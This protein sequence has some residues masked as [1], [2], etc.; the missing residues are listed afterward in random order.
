M[1]DQFPVASWKEHSKEVYAVNWNLATKDTFVS[2]SWDGTIKM[3]NFP[4]TF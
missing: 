4:R 3:V 1:V 2:S